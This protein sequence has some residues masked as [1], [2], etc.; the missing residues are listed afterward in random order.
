MSIGAVYFFWRPFFGRNAIFF[1]R[2]L[3]EVEQLT[4]LTAVRAIRVVGV[5]NVFLAGWAFHGG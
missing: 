4:S 5:F 2:P 1:A 3:A